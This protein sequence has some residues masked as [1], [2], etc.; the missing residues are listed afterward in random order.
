MGVVF[1]TIGMVTG[2]IGR[3]PGLGIWWIGMHGYLHYGPLA[4]LRGLSA[5]TAVCIRPQMQTLAAVMSISPTSSASVYMSTRWWRTQHP[6][7]VIGTE[8]LMPHVARCVVDLAG[9]L[10]WGIFVVSLRYAAEQRHKLAEQR[11]ALQSWRPP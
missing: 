5:A 10:A 6:G 4:D 11:A 3:V 8:N 1:C 7:P 2:S 9:W